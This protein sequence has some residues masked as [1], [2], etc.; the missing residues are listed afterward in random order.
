MKILHL[1]Y[2]NN[3]PEIQPNMGPKCN[4][5]GGEPH[6]YFLYNLL[7]RDAKSTGCG[8]RHLWLCLTVLLI[9]GF[10]PNSPNWLTLTLPIF[11]YPECDHVDEEQVQEEIGKWTIGSTAKSD[12][13]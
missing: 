12:G 2:L 11:R 1:A 3:D 10:A 7:S 8:G 13:Y 6:I 4:P 9:F 5:V